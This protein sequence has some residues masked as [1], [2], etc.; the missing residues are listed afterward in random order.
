M[1]TE[2]IIGNL[3]FMPGRR[4]VNIW[5]TE[6]TIRLTDVSVGG[7]FGE[8]YESL[9]EIVVRL[10]AALPVNEYVSIL[11]WPTKR[12]VARAYL[13]LGGDD[14]WL[15]IDRETTEKQMSGMAKRL[16]AEIMSP[17]DFG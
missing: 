13:F 17:S 11:H 15:P 2:Q 8:H 1:T 4:E 9:T 5:G 3:I 7:L 10:N 12:S 6:T 14:E 16:R